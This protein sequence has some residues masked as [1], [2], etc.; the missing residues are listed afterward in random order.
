MLSH[1]LLQ[2][3]CSHRWADFTSLSSRVDPE[4]DKHSPLFCVS[5]KVCLKDSERGN[6]TLLLM[7]ELRPRF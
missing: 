3:D 5:W 6:D 1:R 7:I 4:L 2:T